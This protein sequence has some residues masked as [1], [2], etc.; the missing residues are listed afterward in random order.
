MIT[1]ADYWMGR[2]VEYA[3][4][5][6]KEIIDNALVLI[7][8]VN[9]VLERAEEDGVEPGIDHDTG[10][11]VSSGWRPKAVNSATPNASR[12]SR[13]M[14]G[15]AVDLCDIVPERALARWCLRNPLVLAELGLWMEDPRWT[16]TWVHLQSIAPRSGDRVFVPSAAPALCA[17][18][19]EQMTTG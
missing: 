13:H 4:E 18:L 7:E 2:D 8:R 19:P 17:A 10:T 12:T 1:L 5:V 15:C 3:G 16:P 6:T 11:A 14:T 9:R